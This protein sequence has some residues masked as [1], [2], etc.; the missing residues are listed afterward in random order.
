MSVM[1]TT[2]LYLS[3]LLTYHNFGAIAFAQ[4]V[5]ITTN[6]NNSM[7]LLQDTDRD[8]I[9]DAAD[10]DDDNDGIPDLLEQGLDTDRDG[11]PNQFDLDSDNDGVG[12]IIEAGFPTL[13]SG[14]D[15]MD[16]LLWIDNNHNGWNDVAENYYATNTSINSDGDGVPDYIDLDSD[17]DSRF[18]IDEAGQIYGD[19]DANGDGI[20]DGN[21]DDHD[22][23]LNVFDN[24]IGFGNIGKILPADTLGTGNYDFKNTN[25]E[26]AI[27][28]DISTTLYAALDADNNGQID[29]NTD[30]DQDG[31]MDAFDSDN[32][33]FGSPRNLVGKYVLNLDGRN[34]YAETTPILGSLPQA[35]IMGWIKLSAPFSTN[36]FI[37]GQQVFN[38]KIKMSGANKKLVATANG[39]TLT[40]A[41]NLDFN[42]WYHIAAVYD[43]TSDGKLKLL[44]NGK[45][46]FNAIAA[47]TTTGLLNTDPSKFTMGKNASAFTEYF[48]GAIDEV[49]VFNTALTTTTIQKMVYQEIRQNGSAIQGEIIPKDFENTTW[50]SLLA[51]YRMD[52]FNDNVLF[53]S[54]SIVAGQAGTIGYARLYNAKNISA[55]TA[56]MPFVTKNSGSFDSAIS[57]NN[58]VNAADAYN[59]PWAI[60]A[61]KHDVTINSNLTT[62]GMIINPMV[63]VN[64]PNN[65]K[66]E[67]SWYLKIDGLLDLKGKSQLVQ[68]INSELDAA[69]AGIIQRGQQGQSNVYNYNYWCSPVGMPSLSSNNNSF[70]VDGVL[71]DGTN[72]SNIQ[73][74][75]WSNGLDGA[76]T[77]PITLSSYW[78]FKF[79]NTSPIYAN[80]SSVGPN[81]T[82]LAGQGFTL[83]G[84]GALTPMQNFTFAGK[85]N[86]GLIT[87]PISANNLNLTG[88]PYPSALD[89]DT[90]I[91]DN[92]GVINGTLYYWEHF[93]TNTSHN[94]IDYQGGY[95]VRNLI[96]GVAPVASVA[97]T[98]FD[99]AS[100]TP[101]RFI[102]VGQG[103][104]V[105]ARNTNGNIVFNNNQRKFIKESSAVSNILF[106]QDFSDPSATR[107][108]NSEDIYT[109]DNNFAKIRIGFTSANNFHRQVLIGF[110]NEFAT[111]GL[112]LGYDSQN[113][114]TLP[115]DLFLMFAEKKLIIQ[116]EGYFDENKIFPIGVKTE[117][118]G[119]VTFMIDHIENFAEN[120]PVY[121]YD[122]VTDLY[123]NLRNEPFAI[124]LP[125]GSLLTRFSIRFKNP[126][127]LSNTDFGGEQASIS[128]AFTNNDQ[129]IN[130]ANSKSD[131]AVQSV[132]LFNMLGQ[133]IANYT[134]TNQKQTEI[135]IPIENQRTGTYIVKVQTTEGDISKK[136]VIE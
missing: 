2:I 25:S 39:L 87:I 55:Q 38:L 120:Q 135:Q 112:D 93:A 130:I 20:G 97:Q 76:P 134:V 62:I 109:D 82:L 60:V 22:G 9:E 102:P 7:L 5:S 96:G 119:N 81:G 131:T 28:T 14:K 50:A 128:V 40:S 91:K 29:G 79:Q 115:N 61:V 114:D 83:K 24:L 123:H 122:N 71:R 77:S 59:Y 33:I 21:D 41:E 100:K 54:S 49:R 104:F 36:G 67:N 95:A 110:M 12:D 94:L 44:I 98:D 30:A 125:G 74:I 27:I 8:G 136:I 37:F 51:Y 107:V 126:N 133:L 65:T 10:L 31:I 99:T 42:R 70:T 103:F 19:G 75:N 73:N 108:T 121:L 47:G 43:N 127:M 1:K 23:I 92:I 113:I 124:N 69:S 89:A 32:T 57:Q 48:N 34:D 52:N 64:L 6:L 53:N 129:T 26:T 90:F 15:T 84:S 88:N 18:D 72:P 78:I 105:N 46:D 86:N 106:R 63:T 4:T 35:T 58:F 80:W 11:I 56:P 101:G 3:L 118:L 132:K 116:G 66:L 85:P 16:L 111:A 13:S 17:N 45:E 117:V 68:T